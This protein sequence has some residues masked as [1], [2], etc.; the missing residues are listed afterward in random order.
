MS[1][2]VL[3]EVTRGGHAESRHQGAVAVVDA[4]GKSVFA[5][6]DIERPVFPR[7]A[8]KI[9]QALPLVE[10]GAA[11]A[12]GF[13][14]AEL[15]LAC[16]S[17][18]AEARQV[19]TARAMLAAAGLAEEALACGPQPPRREEDLARMHRAG[20]VPGRLHNNCSG[21]HAGMLAFARHA[22]ITA[23]GYEQRS[24]E[25]QRAV[26]AAIEDVTGARLA[27][28]PCGID[29]CSLATCAVPLHKLAHGFA[30][31]G[32]QQGFSKDRA[33]ALRRLMA[34]CF[35][36]PFMVAGSGRFCTQ[37]MQSLPGR[38]FV[39][40]GA[41]GVFCAAFPERGLGVAL[42][43]DD[44]AT[45]ASELVMAQII[46]ALVADGTA[47][48]DAQLHPTVTNWAGMQ[49]GT[50]QASATLVEKLAALT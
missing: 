47:P 41:E 26:E 24:H 13:G 21:K 9:I 11:D 31:I 19:E 49:A 7:S 42:K 44:G 39:K 10:S 23:A 43:I 18:N 2:P 33:E 20:G 22:G 35:A 50:V 32:V 48:L 8:I 12:F 15:A 16:S 1:N 14:D 27:D 45:R 40:T 5:I 3:V 25:V 29:G 17:H 36:D 6:G 34:A 37:V 4:Q 30:R 28:V 46:A 38:A